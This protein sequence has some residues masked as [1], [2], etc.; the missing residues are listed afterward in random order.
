MFPIT[1]AVVAGL[2]FAIS[3]L[4]TPT[5]GQLQA[6]ALLEA[7]RPVGASNAFI[8][9]W[10]LPYDIPEAERAAVTEQDID[11]LADWL[12]TRGPAFEEPSIPF[13]SI[14]EGRYRKAPDMPARGPALCDLNGDDCLDRVRAAPDAYARLLAGQNALLKRH[15]AIE[16][17]DHYRNLFEYSMQ[18]PLPPM[19]QMSL[20]LTAAALDFVQGRR[21]PALAAIC[22]GT[23]AWRRLGTHSDSLVVRMV[24]GAILQGNLRTFGHMLAELPVDH[25]LPDACTNAFAEADA[26]ELSLCSAMSG[27]FDMLRSTLHDLLATVHGRERSRIDRLVPVF[28][29]FDVDRTSA[30]AADHYG[31]SCHDDNRQR[32]LADLPF[33]PPMDASPGWLAC[34]GNLVGC[35]LTKAAAPAYYPYQHRVQDGAAQIRV[36]A[37]LLELR[38]NCVGQPARACLAGDDAGR[39]PVHLSDDGG[40]LQVAMYSDRWG[41]HWAIPLPPALID[42]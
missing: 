9:L 40:F 25:A 17:H 15:R 1:T 18:T 22:A 4:V 2:L 37:R 12:A 30:M 42:R 13:Q 29:V 31:W 20:P 6:V 7:A 19:R 3:R 14:A 27:E 8:D 33:D 35:F 38:R 11:R 36:V 26:R 28:L 23:A 34:F 16:R 5:S 10:L 41:A 24:A 32:L 39:R 21:E